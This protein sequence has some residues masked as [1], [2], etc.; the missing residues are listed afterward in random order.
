LINT[1]GEFLPPR[2][3]E[4]FLAALEMKSTLTLNTYIFNKLKFLGMGMGET[5]FTKKGPP[6]FTIRSLIDNLQGGRRIEHRTVYV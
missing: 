3:R 5:L 4:R 1:A 2:P 6:I